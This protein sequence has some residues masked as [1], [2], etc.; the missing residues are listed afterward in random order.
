[1]VA[2]TSIDL[3]LAEISPRL[4]AAFAS[5][6][7]IERGEEALSEAVSYAW[8]HREEV[9]A[10]DNPAGYLY[11]VGQSRSRPRV[12]PR[13]L[14]DPVDLGI[15]DVE[16]A[17]A[18]ALEALTERQRTCVALVVGHHLSHQEVAD[19][20]GIS[21]SSVQHHVMRGMDHLRERLGVTSA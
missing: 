3:L 2:R 14:P 18:P 8:E 11:R 6:Y 4:A 12:T 16:P 7:G 19:L 9:L 13:F 1:M 21:K 20:L 15:P 5:A 17:L 10:M